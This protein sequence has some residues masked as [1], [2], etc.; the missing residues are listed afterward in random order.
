VSVTAGGPGCVD[1][2]EAE[3]QSQKEPLKLLHPVWAVRQIGELVDVEPGQMSEH[4]HVGMQV[5]QIRAL[6]F[7]PRRIRRLKNGFD[8]DSCGLSTPGWLVQVVM[9]FLGYRL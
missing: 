8:R 1:L 6:I 2:P 9:P 7:P 4:V 3:G 5:V